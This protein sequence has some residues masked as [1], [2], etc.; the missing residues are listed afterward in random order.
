MI[1]RRFFGIFGKVFLYTMLILLL[2]IG[3]MFLLFS[4]QIQSTIALT[5]QQQFS[6]TVMGFAEQTQGKTTEEIIVLT[7]D[8]HRWNTSFE[9]SLLSEE[10]E[11]LFQTDGF[12]SNMGISE[13]PDGAVEIISDERVGVVSGIYGEDNGFPVQRFQ[14][15]QQIAF[16]PLGNGLQIQVRG[17]LSGASIYREILGGVAWVFGI[18][19]LVSLLAAFF[20]ARQIAKPIQKVSHDTHM[21]SQLLPVEPPKERS[22][23]IGQLSKDVYAMYSRLRS[24]VYQLETEIERVKLMEENQRYFFSAA[25]HELKTPITAIGGI[26]EG[27][28]SDVITQEEYP[29]YL[30]EGINLVKE[31]NKLV[32]EILELVKLSGKLPSLEKEP[33][34]LHR[35]LAGVLEQLSTLIE[36]KEQLLTVD[37]ADDITCELN[38]RLF[39]K[40]LSNILLNAIQNSP[41]AAEI[42]VTAEKESGLVSLTVWNGSAEIPQ[43]IISKIYEPFYRADEARTP[44]EGRSGLGLTIVKK[45]LDLMGIAFEIKN[46]D[47]GVSFQMKI[48]IE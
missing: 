8:F 40:V 25:S 30:R 38:N 2:V 47:G 14:V 31:Q 39:S 10:R 33:I 34:N 42:R 1:K 24:T 32:S 13:I 19:T 9:L 21:M 48:P 12:V 5:Q 4:N 26:F 36:S 45:A 7:E 3:G 27:M 41:E 44:G 20:F 22:D 43:N 15:M 37:I 11:V 46:A 17:S 35:C 28:M 18:I 16:L 23:E 6:E 29:A